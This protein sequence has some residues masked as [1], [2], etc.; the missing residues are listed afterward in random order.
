M[1]HREV[2]SGALDPDFMAFYGP[3][4]EPSEQLRTWS[5]LSEPKEARK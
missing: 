3:S 5:K 4:W 1:C 2:C